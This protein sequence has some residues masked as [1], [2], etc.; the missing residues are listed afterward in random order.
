VKTT[1]Y[2]IAFIL[3]SSLGSSF[4]LPPGVKWTTSS[5]LLVLFMMSLGNKDK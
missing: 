3:V 2:I 1:I 4:G 5:V